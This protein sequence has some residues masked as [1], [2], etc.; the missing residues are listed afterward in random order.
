MSEVTADVDLPLPPGRPPPPARPLSPT[1]HNGLSV[2]CWWQPTLV[3]H[4]LEKAPE[5]FAYQAQ[6]IR[7]RT[8]LA[9]QTEM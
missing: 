2:S 5:L 6:I 3:T 7:G 4:S 1:S 8:K 9:A